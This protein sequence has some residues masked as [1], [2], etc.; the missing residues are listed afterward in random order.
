M[1]KP[2]ARSRLKTLLPEQ[3]KALFE[4]LSQ[5]PAHVTVAWLAT[6]ALT[7]EPL[8]TQ[9][10][11]LSEFWH[12][13]PL[14]S[15]LHAAASV[16]DTIKAELKELPGLNLDDEQLSKAGQAIFETIAIKNQ[17]SELYTALRKL[18][19]NDSALSLKAKGDTRKAAQK[20]RELQLVERRVALL[21]ENAAEAKAKLTT[22]VKTAGKGLSKEALAQIE[23]AAALL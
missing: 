14:A 21:E 3:Q 4:H 15:Q 23:E 11:S 8:D 5:H 16:T 18:R 19:Q 12:W 10:S 17:D 13:Y 9:D 6:G 1:R 7:G 22:I 2:H 20:D